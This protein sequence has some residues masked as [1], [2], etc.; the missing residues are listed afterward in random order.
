MSNVIALDESY[1]EPT[2]RSLGDESAH[3]GTNW[4][5]RLIGLALSK[6]SSQYWRDA[7]FE[8]FVD[9]F[10]D[11][12]EPVEVCVCGN[13]GLRYVYGVANHVT[14]ATLGPIGSFCIERF[15]SD[16][17]IEQM[18]DMS[19]LARLEADAKAGTLGRASFTVRGI[20]VLHDRGVLDEADWRV[21]RRAYRLG[22]A[23]LRNDPALSRRV[24]WIVELTIRPALLTGVLAGGAA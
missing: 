3:Y 8:W 20:D 6:S 15:D 22:R 16:E 12:G 24:M 19:A 18:R 2:P 11:L 5:N 21:M 13:S 7:K 17:M 9:T 10:D 4:A 1:N 14:G 23:R